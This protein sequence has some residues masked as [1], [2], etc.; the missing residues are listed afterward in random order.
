MV[1][2]IMLS[3]MWQP[4]SQPQVI[5]SFIN[6]CKSC[7]PWSMCYCYVTHTCTYTNA[8]RCYMS[9]RG[10]KHPASLTN[11]YGMMGYGIL[12]IWYGAPTMYGISTGLRLGRSQPTK[13]TTVCKYVALS[14]DQMWIIIIVAGGLAQQNAIWQIIKIPARVEKSWW[15]RLQT[16]GPCEAVW[17]KW[18]K[19]SACSPRVRHTYRYLG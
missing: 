11:T 6:S 12:V 15:L 7:K 10:L 8:N 17:S 18:S 16:Q 9:T 1:E 3:R 13:K 2:V 4:G 14:S 19:E 5:Q